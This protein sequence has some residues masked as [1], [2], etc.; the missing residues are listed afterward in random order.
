MGANL[1]SLFVS[2]FADTRPLRKD[3]KKAEGILKKST[4]KMTGMIK[5]LGAAFL[6]IS[7]AMAVRKAVGSMIEFEK[8]IA[9]VSTLIKGATVDTKALEESIIQMSKTTGREAVEL[10]AGAYQVLSAGI[11]DSADSMLVLEQAAEAGIAGITDTFTAVDILTTAL[12]AYG[13]EADEVGKVSDIL[14][15]TVRLGKTTFG[16]LAGSLGQVLPFSAQLGVSLEEVGA[17][18]AV[19]TSRGLSTEIATTALRASFISFIN[20]ADKFE[21]AGVDILKVVSEDGLI[22]AMDALKEIT[23]G[24]I[25]EMQKF[26]PETRALAAVLTLAG[27]GADAFSDALKE[28]I[29]N[30]GATT[31]AHEKV[32][33]TIDE[34][35][36]VAMANINATILDSRSFFLPLIGWLADSIPKAIAFMTDSFK[37]LRIIWNVLS[38]GFDKFVLVINK[39]LMSIDEAL[40]STLQTLN[41]KGVFDDMIVNLA[42]SNSVMEGKIIGLENSIDKSMSNIADILKEKSGFAGLKMNEEFTKAFAET[43]RLVEKAV[44]E[45]EEDFIAIS[46]FGFQGPMIPT[47]LGEGETQGPQLDFLSRLKRRQ[48]DAA[49]MDTDFSPHL[50]DFLSGIS[51]TKIPELSIPMRAGGDVGLEGIE[52]AKEARQDALM[53]EIEER[54]KANEELESAHAVH[55]E[56]LAEQNENFG[57]SLDAKFTIWTEGIMSWTQAMGDAIVGVFDAVSTGIGKSVADAIVFEKSLV[58]SLQSMMK[59]VAASIIQM[60]VQIGVQKAIAWVA[61]KAGL[62]IISSAEGSRGLKAVYLNTFASASA[63]PFTFLAASTIAQAQTAIAAAGTVAAGG[64]GSGLGQLHDGT[65]FVPKTG[66]YILEKGEAVVDKGNSEEFRESSNQ[67]VTVIIEIDGN[68][69]A[70]TIAPAMREQRKDGVRFE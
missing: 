51:E 30:L 63:N 26:I 36:K 41:I 10:A 20:Q 33:R 23:G 25:R 3:T 70:R 14:F 15:T 19:L 59:D 66:S 27:E 64:L 5:G 7:A 21:E 1:G 46:S 53:K 54:I 31:E 8:K 39:G 50:P 13:M 49:G 45:I 18:M 44:K 68:E 48:L 67:P 2:L 60:F 52:A 47:V 56:R 62:S 32:A 57:V 58:D 65:D 12:N 17:A 4:G 16:A 28:Q 37:G 55:L 9:E 40:L 38:M 29:D 43:E 35:W 34:R 24:N 61:E 11:T 22:G 6:G 69:F 42:I